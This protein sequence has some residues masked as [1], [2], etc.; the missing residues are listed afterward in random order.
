MST[1]TPND[2]QTAGSPPAPEVPP[3]PNFEEKLR[4][5]WEKNSKLVWLAVATVVGVILARGGLEYFRAHKE[6]EIAASYAAASTSEKL[7]N[8][9]AQHPDHPLGA[10]A[11]L[12]LAD[13][14]YMAGK[15]TDAAASYQKAAEVFKSGP[16]GGRA[17]LGAAISKVQAGQAAEGE[18][19]LKKIADDARQPA[20]VRAEAAYQLGTV[21]RDAGRN[22]EAAKRFDQVPALSPASSWAQR[23]SMQRATLPVPASTLTPTLLPTPADAK[24]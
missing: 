23:A 3:G 24:P 4:L 12:R 18:A 16:F 7:K 10:A 14:A 1:L 20:I 22:E 8:F 6:K 9:A 19:A 15:F 13:E 5:F 17:Q 11:Q 2:P 21:A